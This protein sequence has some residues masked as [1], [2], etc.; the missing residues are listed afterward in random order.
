MEGKVTQ[1]HID[2]TSLEWSYTYNKKHFWKITSG[3]FL[4][5]LVINH[6]IYILRNCSELLEDQKE[7]RCFGC[8]VQVNFV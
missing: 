1:A 6:L 7:R 2:H 5:S 8:V 3:S 4:F